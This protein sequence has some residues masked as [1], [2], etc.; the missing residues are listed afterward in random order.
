MLSWA[1]I[2]H[3]AVLATAV[4][5][6]AAVG[7]GGASAAP[8]DQQPPIET[9]PALFALGIQG[10]GQS[11]PDAAVTTDTGMLSTVFRPM[12]AAAPDD[13]LVARAYVPYDSSFG[14]ATS[15]NETPYARSVSGGLGTL[16]SMARSVL[17][18]C[19][20]TRIAVTGYSQGAH[21]ASLFAQEVGAGRG[22][23]PADKVAA[24]ALFGDPTRNPGAPLFPG[25]PGKVTP[26]AVPG[27]GGEA[28]SRI[29]AQP[30]QVAYGG[31]IGPERDV[32]ANFGALT[33]RVAS[34]CT[35]GDLACDVPE[36]AALLKVVANIAG[37]VKLSGGDPIGSLMS[38]GQA[39]AFTSIKTVTDV[40]NNDI[41][42]TSLSNLR[43]SPQKSISQR[44][45]EASDPRN[46]VNIP[47]A[48][49][50]LLKLGTIAI[51]TVV[52]VVRTVLTPGNIAEIATAGLANPLAGLAVLGTKVVG[53]VTQL[54]P[55]TTIDNLVTEAFEAV[56][57][58]LQD[59]KDLFDAN[60]WVRYWQ[61][62]QKHDYSNPQ[63]SDFGDSPAQFVGQWFAA[64]AHDLAGVHDYG[65]APKGGSDRPDGGFDFAPS[66][67]SAPSTAPD[68]QFPLGGPSDTTTAPSTS[69]APLLAPTTAPTTNPAGS[70]GFPLASPAQPQV[71]P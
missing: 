19:E 43:I 52:T 69:P 65:S 25:S 62:A 17:D 30:A 66:T 47:D 37:Q 42:G 46:Q 4:S 56:V 68:G 67:T 26:D 20:H 18:R 8:T 64:L 63:G 1:R 31:G 35:A 14:G 15:A 34:F 57:E 13:G 16:K 28:L 12:L 45:A 50:A 54:V 48:F 49:Q 53:A 22:A 71:I 23:I 36:D 24:V 51:N 40:V 27:T 39:L 29:T 61:T 33:G 10:T 60:T 11:S 70:G 21:V 3:S 5:V 58:N 32:A 2:R 7:I 9:C 41:S 44:L 55:P 38:I 6:I 59:N